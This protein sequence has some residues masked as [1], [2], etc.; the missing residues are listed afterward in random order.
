[1]KLLL[2]AA[3]TAALLSGGISHAQT[4]T[5]AITVPDATSPGPT[6][7]GIT[8]PGLTYADA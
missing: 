1:M 5:G 2:F 7:P 8:S 6:S 3:A 4:N